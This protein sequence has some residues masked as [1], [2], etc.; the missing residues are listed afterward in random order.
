M[1]VRNVIGWCVIVPPNGVGEFQ[2]GQMYPIRIE[3]KLFSKKVTVYQRV[4]KYFDHLLD[5]SK[6][7][8]ANKE[9]FEKTWQIIKEDN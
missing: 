3:T 9:E 7:Q 5:E 1:G 8:F 4:G 6:H 2:V